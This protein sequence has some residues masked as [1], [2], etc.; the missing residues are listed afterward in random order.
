MTTLIR[1]EFGGPIELSVVGPPGLTGTATV[2]AGVQVVPP[3]A[4]A[5]GTPPYIPPVAQLPIHA[6]ADMAPG[7]YEVTIQ[8]KAVADGKEIVAFASTKAAVQAQM[9]GLAYP[10]RHW[11]RGVA[12]AVMPKPPVSLAALWERPESVRSLGNRLV[13]VANR[14]VGFDGEIVLTVVG[15]PPGV[16]ATPNSI[17]AGKAETAIEFRLSEKANL[18]SFAFTVVGRGRQNDHQFT[19]TLQPSPLMVGQPFDL[20]IQPN[21]VPLVA[22]GRATLTVT[23]SRKGGYGGP[24]GLE[25][26]NLPAQVKASRAIIGSG[27]SATTVTLTAAADAPIGSR[28]D[29]DLLGTVRLGNQQAAS[30]AFTVHVQAPPRLLTVKAEPAAVM[31]KPGSKVKIKVTI[32]R[33]HFAGPIAVTIEGLPPKVTAAAVTVPPEQ[34]TAEIELAAAADAD[35]AKTDATVTAKGAVTA[36]AKVNVEIQK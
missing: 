16:T 6:A 29:V 7:A 5:A 19:A 3:E 23:A 9:D 34:S 11:L 25:F 33:K 24:I 27:K 18:G 36:T 20:K 13:V 14:D 1:R 28:G 2:P 30:P 4:P 21:P 35:S 31:L 8:A 17:P 22:G 10:P 15:L 12:V 26:R 32:E